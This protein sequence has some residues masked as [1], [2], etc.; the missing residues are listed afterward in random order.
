[1]MECTNCM[2]LLE[3][4]KQL[5]DNVACVLSG[6]E[7]LVNVLKNHENEIIGLKSCL[8]KSGQS[9]VTPEEIVNE[10]SYSCKSSQDD[11]IMS[12]SQ[13]IV[14]NNV[15]ILDLSNVEILDSALLIDCLQVDEISQHVNTPN[16]SN[17]PQ[18]DLSTHLSKRNVLDLS[19]ISSQE[20]SDSPDSDSSS[21]TSSK[22]DILS[23]LKSSNLESSSSESL[24]CSQSSLN[25][26]LTLT[27]PSKDNLLSWNPHD[28]LPYELHDSKLFDLFE[29]SK[30]DDSTVYTHFFKNRSASYYGSNPYSYGKTYHEARVFSENPYLQKILSYV[31]IVYP[32]FSFNSAMVHKYRSGDDFIPH[33]SDNEEDIEDGS[34]ILTISLGVSRSLEFKELGG[35]ELKE[36]RRLNHGDSLL[37]SQ[38][39]QKYFSH[40]IPKEDQDGTRLS[41]TLRLIES[42]QGPFS[43]KEM[44]TQTKETECAFL[45]PTNELESFQDEQP[46]SPQRNIQQSIPSSPPY[47][48][49]EDGYQ[50]VEEVHNHHHSNYPRPQIQRSTYQ[51]PSY[52]T[53]HD[54][55]IDTVYIS[56]SMFRHLDPNRLSSEQ[57]RAEVLFYPGADASQMLERVM[58]DP[59]FIAL[60]KGKVK[61]VFVMTGTNNVDRIY[62]D[63]SSLDNKV[64]ND[65]SDLLYKLW[66][67]F[68]NAQLNVINILPR[69]NPAK[70]RIV[71]DINHYL[72]NLCNHYGLNFINTERV[73]NLCFSFYNGARKDTL[74]SAGYDNVHL[75]GKGYGVLAKCLKYLAHR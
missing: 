12:S 71:S 51:R 57:Q 49:Y 74:F 63:P 36:V 69:Q 39:S 7:L 67:S 9:I 35:S 30:L 40:G 55:N 50:P 23:S 65:M 33:H 59:K 34:L 31:E 37:M 18:T 1:M 4:I 22:H 14:A 15:D 45:E 75:N 66:V 41:I 68:G 27:I 3:T 29:V 46:E 44:G 47:D 42:R 6:Y 52:A 10:C 73:E 24:S 72:E 64:K 2:I 62:D 19:N 32:T 25:D 54:K 8:N 48:P 70:N 38:E 13:I 58:R 17:I 28:H 16:I 56:S 21:C 61:K 11:I 43:T 26:A 60:D 20:I 53:S 5:N